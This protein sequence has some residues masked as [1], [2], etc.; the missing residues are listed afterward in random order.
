[1]YGHPHKWLLARPLLYKQVSVR[2]SVFLTLLLCFTPDCAMLSPYFSVHTLLIIRCNAVQRVVLLLILSN[3]RLGKP[4]LCAAFSTDK[5]MRSLTTD[6]VLQSLWLLKSHSQEGQALH[7]AMHRG[8]SD[9]VIQ[10]IQMG[11]SATAATQVGGSGLLQ[12]P[13]KLAIK[14]NMLDVLEYLWRSRNDV[15]ADEKS[16]A[17]ALHFAAELGRAACIEL[18]STPSS[19]LTANS[20]GCFWQSPL[21]A[22]AKAAHVEDAVRVLLA[23]GAK[24]DPQGAFGSALHAACMVGNIRSCSGWREGRRRAE[25]VQMILG[26]PEGLALVDVPMQ[27]CENTALHAA[28][29]A[30]LDGCVKALLAADLV[31]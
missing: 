31:T 6:P 5:A 8:R 23:H 21:F 28:A 26:T 27:F 20:W 1:M 17:N 15:R 22:A 10:L 4:D 2:F 14:H 9:L 19:P 24:C 13:L 16:G 3:W 29:R 25:I 18:L 7:K 30:G 12:T 11:V